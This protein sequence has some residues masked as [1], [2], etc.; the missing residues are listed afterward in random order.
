MINKT[1]HR[2]KIM[3][4]AFSRNMSNKLNI[5]V[6]KSHTCEGCGIKRDTLIRNRCPNC[7]NKLYG[8][9][10]GYNTGY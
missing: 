7:Y 6:E 10:T 2:P 3:S 4:D 1:I 9:N 8:D 5:A